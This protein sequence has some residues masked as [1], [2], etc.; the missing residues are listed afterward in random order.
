MEHLAINILQDEIELLWRID[1]VKQLHYVLV[2]LAKHVLGTASFGIGK[3]TK[4]LD[5]PRD[6]LLHLLI[7]MQFE[8]IIDLNGYLHP[9]LLVDRTLNLCVGTTSEV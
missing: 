9:C 5:L 7:S 2:A 3:H 6:T 8:F 1:G 4:Q